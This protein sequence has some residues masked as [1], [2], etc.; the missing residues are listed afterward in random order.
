LKGFERMSLDPGE[1]RRI[2]IKCP[3][4]KV[5]YF[6]PKTNSWTLEKMEYQVYL[7]SSSDEKDLIKSSIKI[8]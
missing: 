3:F 4:E 6:D 5:K 2:S 7:G 8:E 1:S